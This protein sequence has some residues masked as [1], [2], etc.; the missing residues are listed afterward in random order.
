MAPTPRGGPSL[1]PRSSR[2]IYSLFA[3]VSA[4]TKYFRS[5]ESTTTRQFAKRAVPFDPHKKED[6]AFAVLIPILVL[7]SGLFAG[8]TLGYMSLDQTQL[9]VLSVSG[10]PEQRKYANQ[11]KPIR[12][13][14]H[15]LLVTL[16]LANMIVNESLPVIFDEILG[17]GTQ[18]VV[19]S[20]AL[21]VI[22]AEI[23]P[24]S[25]FTRHGLYLGAK[26][27]WITR[28]LILILGIVSW[29]V[30]KFLD[31]SLGSNHG[32]IYRR[33]ELKELIAMHSSAGR[34]G[35]D[36]KTDTVTIIGAT[37]DLQEKV[38][39]QAMT[40]IDEVF[41]LD[42]ESK[43]DYN[44]LKKI[45]ESGHSRV[46]VYEL[47]DAPVDGSLDGRGTGEKKTQKAK[48]IVGILLVKQC[49]LLDPK[50]ATPIRHLQLNKVLFV[51]RNEP[52]LGILDKFQEGRSHI[53]IVSRFSQQKA[54]SV[55]KAVKSTLTQ[56]LKQ[57]VGID[58][59]DSSSSSS[60]DDSSDEEYAGDS[61]HEDGT[62]QHDKDATLRGDTIFSEKDYANTGN[63]AGSAKEQKKRSKKERRK[64]K[65]K[66]EDVE[67]GDSGGS[68]GDQKK[69]ASMLGMSNLEASMP[70][71]AVLTKD[72]AN[73]FLQGYADPALMP[74]GIITLEDVLEELIGEEIYD[75]FDSEGA[76]GEP[77]I[78]ASKT[79][80]PGSSALAPPSTMKKNIN[81][82]R[83]RSAP[84]RPRNREENKD[85]VGGTDNEKAA[86]AGT[87][88]QV[89]GAQPSTADTA[90]VP[91]S[92]NPSSGATKG[93]TAIP[94][95]TLPSGVTPSIEAVL[96]A[97][98]RRH[99]STV[100]TGSTTPRS[101]GAKGGKTFKSGPLKRGVTSPIETLASS[102][103]TTKESGSGSAGA[104]DK[105]L[106]IGEVEER[107]RSLSSDGDEAAAAAV[108]TDGAGQAEQR[109]PDE[110]EKDGFE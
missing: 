96:L 41:M 94:D 1:G 95:V 101:G 38:V 20:T 78:H 42:I 7:L 79:E 8:L 84:G 15:L 100:G 32:I 37:L 59:S 69:M 103:N 36:L 17:G 12:A 46:P 21:I 28:F 27:V 99:V 67:M 13:N 10:T 39:S 86:G 98:K 57:R 43:L 31:W 44:L 29:P 26:G 108:T 80:P 82:L 76:H 6:I 4:A 74:L 60:D 45:V 89:E 9:N 14:G 51:P 105:P 91:V 5:D 65:K 92:T 70:A 63:D 54:K 68:G 58:T 49:V 33:V 64:S 72:G 25:L 2:I 48:R 11:I 3:V 16:L 40:P 35:G 104:G 62:T 85:K 102:H 55:K 22:F 19:I 107:L 24:Q 53:A 110:K 81:F 106:P 61:D 73:E 66:A 47:A 93:T 109:I 87:G 77:Y 23:I 97:G 18:S 71:D 75:E 52:L 90:T 83:S 88:N 34:H 56:R 50:D 30:A